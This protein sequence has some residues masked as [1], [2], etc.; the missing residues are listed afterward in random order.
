MR[1]VK[2]RPDIISKKHEEF[3]FLKVSSLKPPKEDTKVTPKSPTIVSPKSSFTPKRSRL[4]GISDSGDNS[5][6]GKRKIEKYK[7]L[8]L[9]QIQHAAGREVRNSM[10]AVTSLVTSLEAKFVLKDRP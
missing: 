2:R 9:K 8:K 7:K 4:S 3:S 6:N 10:K 5:D 1:M